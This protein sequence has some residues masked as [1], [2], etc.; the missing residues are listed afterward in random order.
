MNNMKTSVTS[1]SLA[2]CFAILVA[3]AARADDKIVGLAVYPPDISLTKK[4]DL[5]RFIVAATRDDGVTLDVTDTATVKLTEA[6]CCRL[7]K[8][9]LYPATDGQTKLE[10]AF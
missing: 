10:V 4:S 8:N 2:A 7:E 1:I 6:K 9:I 5:Q 3:S